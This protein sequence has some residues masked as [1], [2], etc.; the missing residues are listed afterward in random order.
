MKKVNQICSL[1]KPLDGPKLKTGSGILSLQYDKISSRSSHIW[2]LTKRN[3]NLTDVLAEKE[4]P[5]AE[6]IGINVDIS[7]KKYLITSQLNSF[8]PQSTYSHGPN[9]EPTAWNGTLSE[10]FNQTHY[11]TDIMVY[12]NVN[13]NQFT[14][15][16]RGLEL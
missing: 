1:Y 8:Q 11:R 12:H 4:R 3:D 6:L 14:D 9:K 5:K 13:Y 10:R 7:K 15:L 16:G 2:Q